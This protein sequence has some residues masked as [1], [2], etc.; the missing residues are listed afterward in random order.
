MPRQRR[1]RATLVDVARASQVSRQTVSNALNN[2]ERVASDTLE[3][4]QLEIARLGFRPNRAARSLRRRRANAIGFQVE[5]D[6]ARVFNDIHDPFLSALTGCAQADDAHVITF[7]AD[8][9]VL[10]TYDHLLA[11]QVVDGFV[12]AHTHRHDPRADWLRERDVPFV[13]FGRIWDNPTV[14]SWVDVDGHAGTIEAVEHLREAGYRQVAWLGWPEGSP[15]GDD[16][17][18]GWIEATA[19]LDQDAGALSVAVA[20]NALAAADAA[21]PLLGRLSPGDAIACAS[22]VL[23]LGVTMALGQR[24][25]RAGA[26]IGVIGFDDGD[27]AEV[28]D[29]STVRQPL[30]DIAAL[31]IR[32]LEAS[33]EPSHGVIVTPSVV[34]RA[35]TRR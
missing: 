16:R 17:R 15:V 23:A 26:D 6:T 7:V 32:M 1:D 9:D 35:S 21:G 20:Q 10:A 8:D 34:P 28:F 11:T 19:G 24:G 18:A 13:S 33:A 5:R 14:T 3:R 12:L 2:P 30:H 29:L 31:L 27:L 25:L 22:D 4:V